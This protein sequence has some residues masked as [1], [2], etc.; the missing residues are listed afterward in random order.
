MPGA[1]GDK[2][3]TGLPGLP[4][5]TLRLSIRKSFDYAR[6]SMLR[7]PH[8]AVLLQGINGVKGDKGDSGLPGPQGPSV[9][10]VKDVSYD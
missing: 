5:R 10:N 9:S 8:D 3:A 6:Q 4:V 7:V 1:S 2:G